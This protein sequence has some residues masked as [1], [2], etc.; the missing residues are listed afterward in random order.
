MKLADVRR[1]ALAL[2]EVT[3][4]PHHHYGSFRVRGKIFATFPPGGERLH[5]FVNEEARERALELH[6]ECVEKL[7][8]GGK[9]AGIR[10]TLADAAPRVVKELVRAAWEHKAPKSLLS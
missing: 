6:P 9:V 10:V 8:W 2:A 7:F 4:A 5:L 3:E 1:F